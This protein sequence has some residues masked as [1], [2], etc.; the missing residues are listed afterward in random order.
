[1]GVTGKSNFKADIW[2]LPH[3]G[4]NLHLDSGK[5]R[6]HKLQILAQRVQASHFVI[7][8][9]IDGAPN[10]HPRCITILA[11]LE[12]NNIIDQS[13]DEAQRLHCSTSFKLDAYQ[14]YPKKKDLNITD[15]LFCT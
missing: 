7:S 3:H 5:K 15:V 14:C 13:V 1:M 9:I 2:V 8:S 12:N 4:A 11:V 6:M 10:F